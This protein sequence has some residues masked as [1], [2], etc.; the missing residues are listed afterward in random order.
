MHLRALGPED[1][2]LEHGHRLAL[3]VARVDA[4]DEVADTDLVR[5]CGGGERTEREVLCAGSIAF[6]RGGGEGRAGGAHALT[7]ASRAIS[8]AASDDCLDDDA[9]ITVELEQHTN[10]A[11]V[12]VAGELATEHVFGR[13]QAGTHAGLRTIHVSH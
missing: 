12:G 7:G 8:S 13:Q 10:S 11:F 1:E 6:G 2:L 4:R 9:T 3:H 5:S